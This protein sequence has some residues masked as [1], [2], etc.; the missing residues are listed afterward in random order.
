[1][2]TNQSEVN[3][4]VSISLKQNVLDQ[5]EQ[6][7]QTGFSGR[8]DVIRAGVRMLA[9]ELAER[10][11]LTDIADA[12]LVITYDEKYGTDVQHAQHAF[13][14]LVRTKLHNHLENHRCMEI[15]IVRGE[16]KKIRALADKCQTQK[17]V[18]LVKLIVP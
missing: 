14:D 7:R 3:N 17:G 4:I 16:G 8:S 11:K 12:V 5:I 18:E 6:L 10:E 13:G 2:V 15:L 9:T 1:M